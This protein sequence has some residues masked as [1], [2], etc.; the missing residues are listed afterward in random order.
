MNKKRLNDRDEILVKDLQS[1]E[2]ILSSYYNNLH[3]FYNLHNILK[4]TAYVCNKI[5]I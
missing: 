1:F 5:F 2:T 4:Y 3:E